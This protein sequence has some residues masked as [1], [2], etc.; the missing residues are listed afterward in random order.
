M[1]RGPLAY[2]HAGATRIFSGR[3][4]S[5]GVRRR[6]TDHTNGRD[7]DRSCREHKQRRDERKGAVCVRRKAC[8][9]RQAGRCR[10]D[11]STRLGNGNAVRLGQCPH[12]N[13]RRT[14]RSPTQL[15][16]GQHREE[17][18]HRPVPRSGCDGLRSDDRR[19][20]GGPWHRRELEPRSALSGRFARR[21]CF[22]AANGRREGCRRRGRRSSR[23]LG[24]RRRRRRCRHGDLDARSR[25]RRGGLRDGCGSLR[26]GCGSMHLDRRRRGRRRSHGRGGH[27]QERERIKVALGIRGVTDAEVHVRHPELGGAA[28]ADGAERHSLGDGVVLLHC[29]R[30]E[31]RQAHREPRSRLDRHRLAVRRDRPGEAH[32]SRCRRQHGCAGVGADRDAALLARGVRMCL[33]EREGLEQRP[34]HGPRPRARARYE[35]HEQENSRGEPSH[36]HHRLVV[37]IANVESTVAA[38]PAVVNPDYS[39]PR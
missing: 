20:S 17:R 28:R 12:R 36:P 11:G 22:D 5:F 32:D 26:R 1:W 39:E 16:R 23:N 13:R 29:D 9:S 21:R 24:C 34:S 7:A 31:M 2:G 8:A 33:V 4:G 35:E 27:R 10:Q 15:H 30:A 14:R 25:R 37:I 19:S 6:A 38:A 18:A 3:A